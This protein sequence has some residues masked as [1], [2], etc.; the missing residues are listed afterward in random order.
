M[1]EHTETISNTYLQ[2]Q[3]FY[4]ETVTKNSMN[5]RQAYIVFNA[6]NKVVYSHLSL[7]GKAQLEILI[8]D[9]P[10]GAIGSYG[11]SSSN[12]LGIDFQYRLGSHSAPLRTFSISFNTILLPSD[13][14]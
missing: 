5:W 13:E 7:P 8:V 12:S 9:F 6:H 2:A 4:F 1:I 3:D 11:E 10:S 14:R